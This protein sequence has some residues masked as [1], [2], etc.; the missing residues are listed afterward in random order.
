MKAKHYIL[1]L[2]LSG[3][4]AWGAKTAYYT[5]TDGFSLANITSEKYEGS[6][7]T[8]P[9][10]NGLEADEI[11]SALNQE[12]KY[13]SKGHQAYV[14]ESQDSRYVL[15]FIKFQKY[16]HHPLYA[17]LPLPDSLEKDRFKQTLHKQ[18]KRDALFKSWKI[19][20]TKLKDETQVLFVH[21]DLSDPFEKTLT[22]Y[23]KGG[24]RYD[25]DL[26]Q[27]VFLLQKKLDLFED[28]LAS[29]MQKG[30]TVGAK[31]LID[32]LLDLY[33]NEFRQGLYEEDRYIVRN[34]GVL[35]NRPIQIDTGRLRESED[36]KNPKKQAEV[37][38]WK[39]T[40][41]KEWLGETYPELEEHLSGRLDDYRKML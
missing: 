41:L 34:T 9:P 19:A 5:Q 37:M 13:L 11:N 35:Q 2:L 6:L 26:S 14:F 7:W 16:R 23:N 15:K 12:Y 18:D 36:L 39:T 33:L 38:L 27:Y 22:L 30:D 29:Q 4:I 3:L 28:V 21:I 31:Q 25:I 40:L 8:V 32:G 20:H 24:T 17:M 1:G 10:L